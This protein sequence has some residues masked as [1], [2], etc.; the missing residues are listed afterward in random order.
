[1]FSIS[2]VK[3][4]I[5]VFGLGNYYGKLKRGLWA[6]FSPRRLID[7]RTWDELD[8]S[9]TE[10]SLYVQAD[11]PSIG[12]IKEKNIEA[13]VVLTPHHFHVPY[14]EK[15]LKAG[16]PVFLEKPF[17]VSWDEIKI[18]KQFYMAGAPFY[19]SDF[20]LDIRS[21]PLLWF[22]GNIP[23]RDWRFA[24]LRGV[25][26]SLDESSL[27]CLGDIERVE[28]KILETYPV[29]SSWLSERPFGG[30]LW[31]M[32]VHLFAILRFIFRA[33][34]LLINRIEVSY[35]GEEANPGMYLKAPQKPN[36]AECH[37]F[38]EG[39]LMNRGIP[40]SFEV[41]KYAATQERYFMIKGKRG[42]V[43]QRF[44]HQH[45][46]EIKTKKK[47]WKVSLAGDHYDLTTL[48]FCEWLK[49]ERK[50]YGWEWNSWV[51]ERI[52]EIKENI[53]MN[54]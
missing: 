30:V 34:N 51:I 54:V 3:P 20:Y 18:F 7:V 44:I 47:K 46:L 35:W 5:A 26:K 38:I 50:P 17:A 27:D 42:W 2:P 45:P 43:C 23:K 8:L 19:L 13:C 24:F 11:Y 10:R 40:F 1:M 37:A 33:E 39:K 48:G 9:E 36:D 25:D 4:T 14:A 41:G 6:N 15:I 16:I 21:I 52:L 28:G 29:H 49:S 12:L 22:L 53:G 31:D 32:M